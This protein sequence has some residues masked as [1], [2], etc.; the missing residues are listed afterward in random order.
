MNG[1]FLGG[2]RFIKGLL[3]LLVVIDKIRKFRMKGEGGR[4]GEEYRHE[5]EM[6]LIWEDT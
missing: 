1:K 5:K 4:E 6:F 2:F 3:K